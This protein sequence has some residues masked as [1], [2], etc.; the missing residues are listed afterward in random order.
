MNNNN[1]RISVYTD[2]KKAFNLVNHELLLDKLDQSGVRGVVG[3]LFNY[4]NNFK[5]SVSTPFW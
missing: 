5:A 1:K 4:L 3:N 2:L